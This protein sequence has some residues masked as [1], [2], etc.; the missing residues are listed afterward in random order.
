I[1]IYESA[2]LIN[3]LITALFLL[4]QF[5]Q[6]RSRGLLLLACAYFFEALLIIPHA[7]TFPGLFAEKGL[8]GAG[9]QSTAWIYMFWHTGF[10][11]LLIAYAL[12][13]GRNGN[14]INGNGETKPPIG[15]DIAI[16]IAAT[17]GAALLATLVAT[18][19]MPILP[20]IMDGNGYTPA[21][22][23]VVAT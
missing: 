22:K 10:P 13:S 20:V 14:Y 18:T 19:W 7:L 21:L 5:V 12:I 4:G 3:E 11:V 17:A 2:L 16:A 9:G 23:Y 15:L 6:L 1:P 8:L